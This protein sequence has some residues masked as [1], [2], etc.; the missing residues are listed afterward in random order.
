MEVFICFKTKRSSVKTAAM[1]SHLPSANRNFSP[2]KDL[3]MNRAVVPNAGRQEKNAIP[4]EEI[5]DGVP[6]E[7]PNGK[8]IPQCAILVEPIPWFLSGHPK[9]NPFIAAIAISREDSIKK[10]FH[11]K[12]SPLNTAEDL[13]FFFFIKPST[14]FSGS[15]A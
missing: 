2:T 11:R 7:D 9:T 12:D 15:S 4:V 5:P 6:K 13:F 14:S 10:F 8:C 3:P 1:I